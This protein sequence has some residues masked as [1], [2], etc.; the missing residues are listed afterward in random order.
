MEKAKLYTGVEGYEYLTS[1]IGGTVF[2]SEKETDLFH[3]K[4]EIDKRRIKSYF[5]ERITIISNYKD[6]EGKRFND[7]L[8][9][10][11]KSEI[12]RKKAIQKAQQ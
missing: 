7:Y 1:G 5:R 8:S 9:K 11:G 6:D 2:A 3:I 4:I 12:K 10:L